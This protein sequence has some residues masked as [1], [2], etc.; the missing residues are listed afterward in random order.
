MRKRNGV[1]YVDVRRDGVRAQVC[2]GTRDRDVAALL[3]AAVALR[4]RGLRRERFI[5]LVDHALSFDDPALPAVA[6]LVTG[7]AGGCVGRRLAA[8]RFVGWLSGAFPAVRALEEV[9]P[10]LAALFAASLTGKPQT[11]RNVLAHLSA[12]WKELA[13]LG[14]AERNPWPGVMPKAEPGASRSGRA[15]TRAEMGRIVAA[16]DALDAD[17]SMAI[18]L[19]LYTGL[20]EGDVLALRACAVDF[21]AGVIDTTPS[22]TRRF[23][24]R[25]TVP[26][27]PE[28]GARLRAYGVRGGERVL[29]PALTR[30]RLSRA[31]KRVLALAG[32]TARGDELMTFHNLRHTFATWL[33]EA[34]ADQGDQMAL[35]GWST[36]AMA[37]RYD[38]ATDRLRGVVG[39]MPRLADDGREGV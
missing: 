17:V 9:T 13:R 23:G 12:T 2:A 21:A 1:F 14:L 15:F 35:G 25:V 11:R 26:I 36:V 39:R 4:L 33:R 28:L 24:R 30:T 20:R 32:V 6:D 18:C 27:H 38:H 37:R 16:A 19:S 34:G 29:A 5:A 22:K 7:A 3:E 8:A 10:R 31:W